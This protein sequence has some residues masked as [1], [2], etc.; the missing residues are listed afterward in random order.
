MIGLIIILAV[1]AFVFSIVIW[2]CLFFD[3]AVLTRNGTVYQVPN[4][5]NKIALTFDD[6]PSPVWTPFF[7]DELKR[8]GI[9]GTFFVI[10]HHVRAYPQLA[11]RIVQEG[12]LI[13]NHGYA[14]S[15]ILY[16]TLPEIEEEIKYTEQV[17]KEVAGQT[18]QYYR[19][20]KAWL[21]PS[22]KNKIKSLDYTIVLWSINSKDWAPIF[23]AKNWVDQIAGKIKPGDIILFHDSGNVFS[24]EGGDRSETIKAVSYLVETLRK[25]GF[26]FVTVEALLKAEDK[27]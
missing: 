26:E 1:F 10:G 15:V 22:L 25:K 9:K 16:Y 17:I 11:R 12:H 8:L 27:T 3:N 7:L 18:T 23:N 4:S 21:L 13:G 19:P 6:G 5:K 2:F 20:P 14:H 24:A